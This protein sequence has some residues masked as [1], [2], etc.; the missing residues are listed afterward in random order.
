[1]HAT[2]E[3]SLAGEVGVGGGVGAG[4]SS[5]PRHTQGC[6]A[7]KFLGLLARGAEHHHHP[8]KQVFTKTVVVHAT[9]PTFPKPN[10]LANLSH[11]VL[12]DRS[13]L[14]EVN[15]SETVGLTR[16]AQPPPHYRG[17]TEVGRGNGTHARVTRGPQSRIPRKSRCPSTVH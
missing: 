11:E 12:T 6:S 10:T 15:R 2:E 4:E 17:K 9:G 7:R 1:M 8:P 16:K 3:V 14:E 13:A 5:S